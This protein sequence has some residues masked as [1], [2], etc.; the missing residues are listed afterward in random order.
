MALRLIEIFHEEG[1]AEEIAHLLKEH[2]VL[3]SWHDSLPGGETVSRVL[4]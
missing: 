1:K 4:P 2:P 3:H